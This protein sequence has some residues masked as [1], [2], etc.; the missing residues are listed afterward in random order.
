MGRPRLC[1][2]I[3][4]MLR[5]NKITNANKELWT[6]LSLAYERILLDHNEIKRL[7]EVNRKLRKKESKNE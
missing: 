4:I 2:K 5:R 1:I 3:D 7:N 6:M